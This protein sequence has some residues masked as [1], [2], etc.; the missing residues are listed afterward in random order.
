M[1]EAPNP[2]TIIC[3]CVSI[4]DQLSDS[5]LAVK[6]CKMCHGTGELQ[7]KVVYPLADTIIAET[8]HGPVKA[9]YAKMV[10]IS[11]R[12]KKPFFAW[13]RGWSYDK[14]DQV[15]TLKCNTEGIIMGEWFYPIE[16]D[17]ITYRVKIDTGLVDDNIK[18]NTR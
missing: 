9:I 13:A 11:S 10:A 2:L 17:G 12:V 3:P 1:R 8:A 14:V 18:G 16:R 15:W 7:D 6:D 4:A 5:G